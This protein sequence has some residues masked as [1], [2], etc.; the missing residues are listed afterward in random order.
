MKKFT[1]V[2][3]VMVGFS[4]MLFADGEEVKK[5]KKIIID[6]EASLD[7]VEAELDIDLKD[8]RE[9]L[10]EIKGMQNVNTRIV[11]NRRG[12]DESPDAAYFGLYVED[13]DFPKA[14]VLGYKDT[15]GV[16]ITGVVTDSP[17]WQYRL[18]EDDIIRSINGKEISNYEVFEK[19]RKTLRAGDVISIEL[20]REG[21]V[22]GLDMTVGSR[23]QDS[24]TTSGEIT[25]LP[26]K[27]LS[28]GYG[29]GSYIPMWVNV[30]MSDI[31][32]LISSPSIDF[33][34]FREEGVFQQ[35][36]GG[37]LPV[38]KGFFIGGQV[39][40]FEDTK[41]TSN[42]ADP[43]YNI[44]LRYNNT[45]GGVTLDKRI[46]ITKNL[47]TSVGFMLGGAN[48][49]MEFINTDGNYDWDSMDTVIS[50]SNNTHFLINKTYALVQPRAEL[51][52][53]IL[54]WL[55]LRAEGGYAYGYA[56]TEDWRVR[57]MEGDGYTIKNSPKTKY[58]GFTVSIGPWFG[59]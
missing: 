39:T 29:G 44:W 46:P 36:I 35:G 55:G 15:F 26:K 43:T 54:P 5:T 57:G 30:D 49:E 11:V 59:F 21:K 18:Q 27:K 16:V 28:A 42:P 31:N 53:R 25:I 23:K 1:L 40:T 3:L 47:I 45:M 7:E 56:L 52:Y 50:A 14:Q 10:N 12:G 9:A 34:E 13:L 32:E 37:K 33:P 48:H 4:M 6:A 17:S 2:L 58:E 22:M 24:S 19:V 38:G 51:M 20:F 8:A 41:K